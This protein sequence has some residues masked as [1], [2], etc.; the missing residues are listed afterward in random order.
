MDNALRKNQ[1]RPS[2]EEEAAAPPKENY[3]GPAHSFGTENTG[4]GLLDL[5]IGPPRQTGQSKQFSI[6]EAHDHIVMGTG[7]G[8][9]YRGQIPADLRRL[10]GPGGI[11]AAMAMAKATK[12]RDP[13]DA[14]LDL[15]DSGV[16]RQEHERLNA[17]VSGVEYPKHI[18][19]PEAEGWEPGEYNPPTTNLE[20]HIK[21]N[22][23]MIRAPREISVG[24]VTFI[25]QSPGSKEMREVRQSDLDAAKR[26]YDDSFVRRG[27]KIPQ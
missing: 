5:P 8:V 20:E 16:T 27:G 13:R 9:A 25:H 18:R 24:S 14:G 17:P 11:A 26:E 4:E 23:N 22:G 1:G 2:R 6:K 21:A 19:G 15:E 12:R 3:E 7:T 10:I